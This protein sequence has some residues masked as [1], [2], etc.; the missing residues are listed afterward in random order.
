MR[1]R[2]RETRG[3]ERRYKSF[4][5]VNLCP[6]FWL[7][8]WD[9]PQWNDW[10]KAGFSPHSPRSFPMCSV[11]TLSQS[12]KSLQVL[13]KSGLPG[14]FL[15]I[16]YLCQ[17]SVTIIFSSTLSPGT[18]GFASISS[19]F[20]ACFPFRLLSCLPN[21]AQKTWVPSLPVHLQRNKAAQFK[22]STNEELNTRG[23]ISPCLLSWAGLSIICVSRL[24]DSREPGAIT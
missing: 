4:S 7:C 17:V 15:E 11:L 24:L 18:Q 10:A 16:W 9:Q 6:Y 19:H 20:S 21:L 13:V 12:R 23:W 5:S 14:L 3:E 1:A 2:G 22:W 8:H